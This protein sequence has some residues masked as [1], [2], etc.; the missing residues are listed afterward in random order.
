MLA[1]CGGPRPTDISSLLIKEHYP[2]EIEYL[3]TVS[4]LESRLSNIDEGS[5]LVE[6]EF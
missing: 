4:Y 6:L 3:K 5:I 1:A 2:N